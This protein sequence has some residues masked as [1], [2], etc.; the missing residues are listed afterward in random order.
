VAPD[1]V[2]LPS[3]T[4]APE[5]RVRTRR[6]TSAIFRAPSTLISAGLVGAISLVL[7]AFLLLPG[8]SLSAFVTGV[9]VIAVPA[10]VSAVATPP[11]AAAMEGRFRLRRSMLLAFTAALVAVP[12]VILLRLE[13]LVPGAPTLPAIAVLLGCQG[14][15]LW[16]RHMTLFGVS[17]PSHSRSLPPS[18]LQPVLGIALVLW[19]YGT[20]PKWLVLAGLFLVL[21]FLAAALLLRA[22]DRPIRREFG[23]SGVSLLRP[24]FDHIGLRDP[25]ATASLERFF[26]RSAIPADLRL[27][28]MAFRSGGRTTATLALPTVHPGP[29]AALGSS[30]LPRKLAERLGTSAGVVLVPHT[31]CN[32]DLDLP[33]GA[34]VDQVGRAAETLLQGL[35]Y[36]PPARASGLVA[37]RPDSWA[38]AQ[39]LGDTVLL[40]VTQAPAPTDDIDYAVADRLTREISA[41]S[42]LRVAVIDAHNS[43]VEDRGDIT[44]GTP[45]AERLLADAV[46]AVRAAQA[47][48]VPGPVE[49]GVGV[50]ENYSIG[51]QGIGPSG[52]RALV[53]RAGGRTTAYVLI[54]GNNLLIGL[55]EK[56]LQGLH[57]LVD[58]AEVMTT[59]NH[60]V[61][62]VDGSI[63]AV[64]EKYPLDR[65]VADVRTTVTAALAEMRPAEVGAGGIDL[66]G[67]PVLG[68]DATARLLTSLGDTFSMFTNAFVMTFLM[69]VASTAAVLLAVP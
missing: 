8:A 28:L 62:E 44:Y 65:L 68:P 1:P 64:G 51:E 26:H 54:D 63:N 34:E 13:A 17:N 7:P 46:A 66:P 48:A 45:A 31:P 36:A 11:L 57:G 33:S 49:V 2:G 18:L 56:I 10:Y 3:G 23:V 42:G 9:L 41:S 12:L 38:R 53:L 39:V 16:L 69:L 20:T 6:Y 58:D 59:D 30:D 43:Y 35:P 29:F 37:P 24:V 21:G 67:V 25:A 50:R 61:H 60:V 52:I 5:A 19:A 4:V 40:L 32:H 22:A 55:R 27:T 15:V 47:A 14:F